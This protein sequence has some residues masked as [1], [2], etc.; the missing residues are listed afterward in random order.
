MAHRLIMFGP[1][2][3]GKGTQAA[4]LSKSIG[5]PHISTGQIFR[6]AQKAGTELGL[7]AKSYTDGGNY[8]PDDIVIGIVNER[9]AQD[10][11]RTKGFILDGVPRTVPQAKSLRAWLKNEKMEIDVVVELQVEKEI[12]MKRLAGRRRCE[13]CNIDYNI[14][15]KPPAVAGKCDECGAAIVQRVDDADEAITRRFE[16]DAKMAAPL[17]RYYDEQKLLM[18]VDGAGEISSISE[19]IL[20]RIRNQ[21]VVGARSAAS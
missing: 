15:F 18:T 2:G 3:A 7:L 12:L 5:A 14:S 8:V 6:E 10:D 13:V 16:V 20:R 9:L 21:P 11:A 1:P 17:R 4:I 19:E